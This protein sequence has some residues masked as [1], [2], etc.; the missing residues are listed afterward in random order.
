MSTPPHKQ[1]FR[2]ETELAKEKLTFS[3]YLKT[4]LLTVF[5]LRVV[6]FQPTE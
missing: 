3:A 1:L 2:K 4:S 6:G 5:V